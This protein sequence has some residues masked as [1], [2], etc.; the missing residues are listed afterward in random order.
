MR[1]REVPSPAESGIHGSTGKCAVIMPPLIPAV[2]AALKPQSVLCWTHEKVEWNREEY[3][4]SLIRDGDFLW[5][6]ETMIQTIKSDI[7]AA[8]QRD[9]AARN[10]ME[11][12]ICYPSIH[13]V[14]W[15]RVAHS[16]YRHHLYFFARLISQIA[17]FFTGI[18]IHPGAQIG[19]GFFIDHGMGVVIGET[20]EIG[21]NVTLYQSVTLGGTGKDVGKRHPTIGDNV[22]VGAGAKVLGPLK[23]GN[24]CKIGAGTIVLKDIPDHCTVVGNPGRVVRYYGDAD[25]S[26]IET[27]NQVEL[28]DPV[29]TDLRTLYGKIAALEAQLTQMQRKEKEFTN[30]G[31]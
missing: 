5:K 4:P 6:G 18:E 26:P 10:A 16:L 20:C 28:P 11:V 30:E 21:N 29:A 2:G 23:V 31:L 14:L 24:N 7:Q 17:R 15:Y 22:L 19:D 8:L 3:S 25:Q 13:A 27:M 1:D 12:I 9:P